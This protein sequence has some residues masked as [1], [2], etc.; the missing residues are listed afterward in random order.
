MVV[1]WLATEGVMAMP[2]KM[3]ILDIFLQSWL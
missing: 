1:D 2:V 3:I